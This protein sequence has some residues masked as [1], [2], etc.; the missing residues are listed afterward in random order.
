M[1]CLLILLTLSFPEQKFFEEVQLINSWIMVWYSKGHHHS[2]GHSGFFLYSFRSFLVLHPMFRHVIHFELTFVK[3]VRST[4]RFFF[5]TWLS[6]CFNTCLLEYKYN[7][8]WKFYLC[9]IVLSWHLCQISADCIYMG[10]FLSTV[11]CSTD[12]SALSPKL[13]CLDH[14]KF[15]VTVEGG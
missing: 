3:S 7:I 10:L 14:C 11:F 4:S 1:A 12:L 6:N 8:C 5:S 2:L 9:Y 15:R 13:H